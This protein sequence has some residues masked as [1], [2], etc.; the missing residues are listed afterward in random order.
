VVVVVVVVV[1]LPLEVL[2]GQP[3]L[4]RM[5][6]LLVVLPV[7]EILGEVLEEPAAQELLLLL[8]G[9]VVVVVGM[10]REFVVH[11]LEFLD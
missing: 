9:K 5:F 10:H 1:K 3:L 4:V 11:L 6:L 2:A 7:V 8:K